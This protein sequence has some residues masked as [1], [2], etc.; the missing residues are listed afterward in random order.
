MQLIAL[1]FQIIHRDQGN[2]VVSF[3]YGLLCLSDCIPV[4]EITAACI[5]FRH[6]YSG[7]HNRQISFSELL[8][9]PVNQRFQIATV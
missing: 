5:D 2:T 1:F 6:G 3:C 8:S 4:A 9:K 7:Y